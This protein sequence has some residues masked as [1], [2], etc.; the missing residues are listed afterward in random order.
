[1]VAGGQV[2]DPET[3]ITHNQ[4]VQLQDLV[5]QAYCMQVGQLTGSDVQATTAGT[6]SERRKQT[7]LDMSNA[8][9]RAII[10][11]SPVIAWLAS[12]AAYMNWKP[13]KGVKYLERMAS[14]LS[15]K[16]AGQN[17]RVRMKGAV[18]KLALASGGRNTWHGRA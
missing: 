13:Q 2:K 10:H 5:V 12:L 6:C 7:G 8:H 18:C 16:A 4:A 1:M 14:Q 9:L 11:S 3:G 15:I 17:Q